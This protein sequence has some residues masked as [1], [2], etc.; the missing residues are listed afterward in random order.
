MRRRPPRSTRTDTLFPYTALFRSLRINVRVRNV[1]SFSRER[2]VSLQVRNA[3]SVPY[4]LRMKPGICR[5]AIYA[6]AKL[7]A[8]PDPS[9]MP[10]KNRPEPAA[11]STRAQALLSLGE[12]RDGLGAGQIG[13]GLTAGKRSSGHFRSEEDTSE[14]Q[15]L[16]R[17]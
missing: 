3:V 10:I 13:A 11:P 8:G 2:K 12:R 5:R 14:L 17:I 7:K 4:W 16:M 9:S 6:G 15:S 1:N